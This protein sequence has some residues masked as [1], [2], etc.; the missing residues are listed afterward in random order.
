MVFCLSLA[1]AKAGNFFAEICTADLPAGSAGNR[2]GRVYAESFPLRRRSVASTARNR[3]PCLLS[4]VPCT[5]FLVSCL[6]YVE[7]FG[8]ATPAGWSFIL[9]S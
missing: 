3:M 9:I 2:R 8:H 4:L 6:L 5:L 7:S 1:V